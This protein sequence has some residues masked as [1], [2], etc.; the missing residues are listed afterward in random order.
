VIRKNNLIARGEGV[1]HP[2][3]SHRKGWVIRAANRTFVGLRLEFRM[4]ARSHAKLLTISGMCLAQTSFAVGILC[5]LAWILGSLL[6]WLGIVRIS[7]HDWSA[8]L[9]VLTLLLI[10]F[11]FVFVVGG[12]RKKYR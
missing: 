9:L 3:Q 1:A 4:L 11:D 6:E 5:F 12:S 10:P 7:A 8:I 2:L